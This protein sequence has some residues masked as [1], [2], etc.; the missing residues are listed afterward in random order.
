MEIHHATGVSISRISDFMA[1]GDMRLE[2]AGKIARYLGLELVR[3]K[4]RRGGKT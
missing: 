3:S 1:G 2:N 4:P